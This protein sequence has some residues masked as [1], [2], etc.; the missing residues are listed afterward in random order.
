MELVQGVPMTRYCDNNALTPRERLELFVPVC[1]AI[2][3][4]HQRGIIHR[5]I[6]PSNVLVSLQDGKAVPKVIDFGIAKAV[7]QP[8]LAPEVATQVGTVVGTLEYMSP[9][10]AE[11]NP[12][13]VDTRSDV[14]SLGV[15]LYELLTGTTPL[16][17]A[18]LRNL[19]LPMAL[20]LIEE[21]EAPRP[22]ARLAE[23]GERLATIAAR[24]KTEPTRLAKQLRGELDWI[25]LK[26]LEKD[27][28]RRYDSALSLARDVQRHL[29]DEPV[30]ACPPSA[31]Y[32]MRKFT[33]RHR[34]LLAVASGFSAL[35]VL[36]VIGLIGGLVVVNGARLKAELALEA[37]IR[38]EKQQRA[39]LDT[40]DVALHAMVRSGT[41]LEDSDKAIMREALK[42]YRGLVPES[43]DTVEV[44]TRAADRYAR[45]AMLQLLAE[46]F[47]EAGADYDRAIEV[48]EG[49]REQFSPA[50]EHRARL[51]RLHFERGIL[52]NAQKRPEAEADYRQAVALHEQLAD[53]FKA[54]PHHRLDLA[55]D[56][57][58]LGVFLAEHRQPAEGAKTY[59]RAIDLGES[60]IKDFPD[61]PQYKLS[62]GA[63]YGNL[64][65]VVR[66]QGQP[67]E[68]L[69][70]YDRAEGLLA[71][72]AL[73]EVRLGR[74][75]VVLRNACWDRANA[76][77]QLG[78]HKEAI[79][80]WQRAIDLD[81]GLDKF[82]LR[83]FL[84]TAR[85]EDIIQSNVRAT[86]EAEFAAF[87]YD[88]A[89]VNARAAVLA[90]AKYDS[91]LQ[92]QYGRRA[93]QLLGRAQTAGFF[94]DTRNLAKL[95]DLDLDTLSPR[96]DFQKL[97]TELNAGPK[98]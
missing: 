45:L 4:A 98:K 37:E 29:A 88:A 74:A 58:N 83:N 62:L 61:T 90:A 92:E 85:L 35:V 60:L 57:N 50:P 69:A 13:G 12:H 7:E 40:T 87:F 38:A 19:T 1:Q 43:G 5:D 81:Y 33:R 64:G 30:E 72:L 97:L 67:A 23:V 47:A 21:E 49:L 14:Y 80:A 22:S 63:N 93:V 59:R 53:E 89:R 28:T 8:L 34:G 20:R 48:C 70:W 11:L 24:R 42:D 54:E 77:G 96:P 17:R 9:E 31:T 79:V 82:A 75:Q 94:K 10:Q 39:A 26:A 46:D 52:R 71:P 15:L 95:K 56:L 91:G 2:Q 18:R 25:A 65:N 16:E 55:N 78:R 44:R 27:R 73:K 41:R 84:L 51:A 66:D 68:A 32:Q 36:G 3:H 6:K 86:N 76:L